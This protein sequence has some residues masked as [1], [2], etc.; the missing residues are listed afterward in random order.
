MRQLAEVRLPFGQPVRVRPHVAQGQVL[1]GDQR[2]ALDAAGDDA[3]TR[4]RPPW[5]SRW[6]IAEAAIAAIGTKAY[7]PSRRIR[8]SRRRS[9]P[10]ASA[11]AG[12]QRRHRQA[13]GGQQGAG[14]LS[15]RCGPAW[16]SPAVRRARRTASAV[17]PPPS[18]AAGRAGAAAR[19]STAIRRARRRGRSLTVASE[20][21]ARQAIGVAPPSSRVGSVSST[22]PTN[23]SAAAMISPSSSSRGRRPPGRP[24][25]PGSRRRPPRRP[26]ACSADVAGRHHRASGRCRVAARPLAGRAARRR[27]ARPA[28]SPPRSAPR[29]P[30]PVRRAAAAR[31]GAARDRPASAVAAIAA[32]PTASDAT[33][34]HARGKMHDP[35]VPDQRAPREPGRAICWDTA[36]TPADRRGRRCQTGTACLS[37]GRRPPPTAGRWPAPAPCGGPPG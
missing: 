25:T 8:S 36:A 6:Y 20:D 3:R 32:S 7:A 34:D 5:R 15:A 33:I 21:R 26:A 37:C 1:P 9:A 19:S 18:A 17:I 30:A 12:G 2:E 28:G 4:R 14:R 31:C 35:T 10:V 23:Q 13:G 27:A 22:Q 24:Q 11:A 16:Q 29:P